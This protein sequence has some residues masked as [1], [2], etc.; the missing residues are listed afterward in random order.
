MKFY[1]TWG[2]QLEVLPRITIIY[3]FGIGL[4]WLWFGLFVKC[5]F[6]SND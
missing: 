1:N 4:E 5:T 6:D 2:V 3:D